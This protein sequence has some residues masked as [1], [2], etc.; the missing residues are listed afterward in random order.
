MG[1]GLRG[2]GLRARL[3]GRRAVRAGSLAALRA[4]V[5]LM[6]AHC[7]G[8]VA[9]GVVRLY[10]RRTFRDVRLER[11]LKHVPR[12]DQ[13]DCRRRPARARRAGS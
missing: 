5:E 8:G 11:P 6:I 1:T 12:V 10:D 9:E 2:A 4:E 7:G 13:Q 3:S